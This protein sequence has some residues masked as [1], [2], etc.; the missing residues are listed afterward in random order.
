M[1]HSAEGKKKKP[2]SLDGSKLRGSNETEMPN[3]T[4]LLIVITSKIM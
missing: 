1:L 4:S 2:S 3:A